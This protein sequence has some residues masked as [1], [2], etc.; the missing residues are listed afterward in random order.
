M[1]QYA[2]QACLN[3]AVR[4]SGNTSN[5]DGNSN[6]NDGWGAPPPNVAPL[7]KGMEGGDGA[8]GPMGGGG[9][10]SANGN[11]MEQ[12]NDGGGG[13]GAKLDRDDSSSG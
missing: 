7:H 12:S 5:S 8:N 13:L 3:D 10:Y 1:S 6:G 2:T 9:E 11:G 4:N